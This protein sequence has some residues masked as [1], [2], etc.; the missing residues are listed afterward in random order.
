MLK[1]VSSLRIVLFLSLMLI[2]GAAHAAVD[3]FINFEPGSGPGA[4]K[5]D[6]ETQDS[7][8]KTLNALEVKSVAFGLEN[9]PTIGSKTG[10]ASAGKASFKEISI[11][12]TPGQATNK[13]FLACAM[14]AH[15]E[16]STIFFRKA[17]GTAAKGESAKP[18]FT[19]ELGLVFVKS[20]DFA[21]A[22]GDEGPSVSVV[23]MCGSAKLEYTA[24]DS[25]GKTVGKPSIVSWDQTTNKQ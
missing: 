19:I 10:G 2:A 17:G 24:Q 1:I 7:Y 21:A 18:Y 11:Q 14:G 23:L 5:I 13:L 12:L 22:S 9:A 3:T 25:S 8:F 16:K 4:P 15:F 20:I 6:A